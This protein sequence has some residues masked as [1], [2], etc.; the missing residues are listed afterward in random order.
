MQLKTPGVFDISFDDELDALRRDLTGCR[1]VAFTD[2][3]AGMVLKVS[4]SERPP[5]EQI[6]ALGDLAARCL[7]GAALPALFDGEPPFAAVQTSGR[8]SSYF[9]RSLADPADA[10]ILLV[11]EPTKQAEVWSAAQSVLDRL[12]SGGPAS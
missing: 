12:Q 2:L 9:I 4:A 8:E 10:L 11:A 3:S 1:L 7:D 6:D 5:R